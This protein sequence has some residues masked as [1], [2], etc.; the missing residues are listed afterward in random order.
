MLPEGS[1]ADRALHG[2]TGCARDN[3][4]MHLIVPFAAPL[5]E[6]GR[7]AART[8]ARPVLAALRDSLV[9]QARDDGDEWSLSPPHERAWARA[10]GWA[11]ADGALPFAAQAAAAA[12]I[13][14][15]DLA[16]A[17]LTPV[18]WHLG[19]EQ[20]SLVDPAQ[21]ALDEASSRALLEAVRPLFTG[22]GWQ[23]DGWTMAWGETGAWYAA[24]ESLA[25]LPTASLD[26]VIGR[27][28]DAW[29]G[30]NTAA[31][32]LR[33]LQAELQMLLHAHPLN[34]E[35][36]ARGLLPVNSVWISGCGRRQPVAAGAEPVLEAGLRAPALAGDWAAW[37]KAFDA[38]EAGVLA[39]LLA[40]V[41]RGDEVQ[42]TLCGE[43]GSVTLGG[44]PRTGF[45][46]WWQRWGRTELATWM[47]TL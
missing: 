37:C 6:E 38:I 12:G 15:G 18:H 32:P 10:V 35:R 45:Q 17:R 5:P 44:P 23:M 20:V 13:D 11:G 40:R 7:A 47:E 22:D 41:E 33:R 25:E 43:R 19:T 29:L 30:S 46:R 21:L 14:T 31:R 9:E 8:L 27:N 34:A 1:A 3:P 39:E 16:W 4:P 24:H 26:R 28:V 42:L 36:E 2:I